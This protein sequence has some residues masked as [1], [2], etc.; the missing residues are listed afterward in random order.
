L[1]ST[2]SV[3]GPA[4]H[5]L[6]RPSDWMIAL[7]VGPGGASVGVLQGDLRF[8]IFFHYSGWSQIVHVS[9]SARA[10]L[11]TDYIEAALLLDKP[12]YRPTLAEA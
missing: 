4:I 11:T 7:I 1:R 3:V 8:N 12:R 6:L 9:F 5:I 2:D 10:V